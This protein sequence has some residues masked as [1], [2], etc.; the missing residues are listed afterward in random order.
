MTYIL[1]T[2][3]TPNPQKAAILLEELGQPYE[4]RHVDFSRNE[5]KT[6]EFQKLNPNGKVPVLID[7]DADGFTLVESGA[8]LLY[9]AEKNGQFLPPDPLER[10]ETVQWVMWQMAGLGPMFGQFMFFAAAYDNGMPKAT[11]RYQIEIM[12]LFKLLDDRLDG[13][14][15]IAADQHTVADMAAWPWITVMLRAQIP[16]EDFPNIKEWYDRL[17]QRQT[18]VDGMAKLGEKS[19]EQRMSGFKL[20]TVGVGS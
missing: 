9:L 8:I 6:P 7:P 11:E 18:Y 1:Y 14:E 17:A 19:E 4:I 13:R 10:S 16:M 15:Y 12:R 5:Q 2:G 3:S 20:A